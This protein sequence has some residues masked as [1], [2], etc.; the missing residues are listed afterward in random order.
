VQGDE[1]G[2][3][4][5]PALAGSETGH[6]SPLVQME[7]RLSDQQ[8]LLKGKHEMSNSIADGISRTTVHRELAQLLDSYQS[9][10]AESQ[11]DNDTYYTGYWDSACRTIYEVAEALCIPFNDPWVD[12]SSGRSLEY[13][14]WC[15]KFH[16]EQTS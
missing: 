5:A 15:R 9:E 16:K 12:P 6:C 11:Q 4:E 14:E 1:T 8:Q 2:Q 13:Q 10:K 7:N 3:N